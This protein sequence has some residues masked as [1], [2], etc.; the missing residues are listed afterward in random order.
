M[1]S[2][3]NEKIVKWL[4][5]TFLIHFFVGILFG[6]IYMIF[7]DF[8]FIIIG[9]TYNDPVIT[10]VLGAAMIGFAMSS[11]LAWRETDW[12]KVKIIVQMEMVWLALGTIM[13]F[14]S[15]FSYYTPI[16]IWVVIAI[17]LAFLIAFAYFYYLQEK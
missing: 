12:L 5:L 14:I 7:P 17:F 11:L 13:L 10:R 2:N 3:M 9:W 6:I 8:F 15:A 4:K 1:K 16:F